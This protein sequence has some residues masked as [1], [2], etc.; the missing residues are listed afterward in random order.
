MNTHHTMSTE[1]LLRIQSKSTRTSVKDVTTDD[2]SQSP[3]EPSVKES[4][5]NRVKSRVQISKPNQSIPQQR[6]DGVLYERVNDEAQGKGTPA[7]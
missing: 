2:D 6:G 5:D 4:I 1:T 3:P 7:D